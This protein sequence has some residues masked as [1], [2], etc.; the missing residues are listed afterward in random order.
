MWSRTQKFSSIYAFV[1]VDVI[2]TILW[3]AAFASVASW[4]RAGVAQGAT[5]AKISYGSANCT[6]FAYGTEQKCHLGNAATGFGVL[7]FLVFAATSALSIMFLMRMRRDTSPDSQKPWLAAGVQGDGY[8]PPDGNLE[9]GRQSKDRIWDSTYAGPDAEHDDDEA[10]HGNN[11]GVDQHD[12]YALLH[13]TDNQDASHPG[14]RWEVPPMGPPVD[15]GYHGAPSSASTYHAPSAL[16]PSGNEYLSQTDDYEDNYGAPS[17]YPPPRYSFTP[18]EPIPI[19]D[20]GE[21]GR[22]R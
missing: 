22:R 15:T 18:G 10:M 9:A 6:V 5:D 21:A 19:P 8:R 11:H 4:V 16:S 7:I 3:L 17:R 20:P 12:D 14:R 2:L 13:A 1:S